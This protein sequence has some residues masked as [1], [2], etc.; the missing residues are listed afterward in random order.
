MCVRCHLR[1]EQR[2]MKSGSRTPGGMPLCRAS[3]NQL[4]LTSPNVEPKPAFGILNWLWK[5]RALG[6]SQEQVVSLWAALGLSRP[7]PEVCKQAYTHPWSRS[8]YPWPQANLPPFLRCAVGAQSLSSQS[9]LG[10]G[11]G[12]CAYLDSTGSGAM[13][14]TRSMPPII[15]SAL[16]QRLLVKYTLPWGQGGWELAGSW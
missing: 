8:T 4:P 11:G 9:H 3:G 15:G 14:K 6:A 5:E 13:T 16:V 10:R 7:L 2:E 12:M 1:D